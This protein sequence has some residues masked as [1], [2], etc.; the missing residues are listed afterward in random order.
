MERNTIELTAHI[1][2]IV[3]E[4]TAIKLADLGPVCITGVVCTITVR[5]AM[6]SFEGKNM[7][8]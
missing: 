2:I 6:S 3:D 5:G 7:I 8:N 1:M 4:N